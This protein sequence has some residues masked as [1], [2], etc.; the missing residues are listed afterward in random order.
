MNGFGLPNVLPQFFPGIRRRTPAVVAHPIEYDEQPNSAD[1]L[2]VTDPALLANALSAGGSLSNPPRCVFRDIC[3]LEQVIVQPAAGAP[4]GYEVVF[5]WCT[6]YPASQ[7]PGDN[8]A[9]PSELGRVT[10]RGGC[11]C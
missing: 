9:N 7:F 2:L 3:S 8:I 6:D 4:A 5:L 11:S 10:A 1:G